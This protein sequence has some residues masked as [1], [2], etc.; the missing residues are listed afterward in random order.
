MWKEAAGC[1]LGVVFGKDPK[2]YAGSWLG[3]CDC[4]IFVGVDAFAYSNMGRKC[5]KK[6]RGCVGDALCHFVSEGIEEGMRWCACA[7]MEAGYRSLLD[8]GVCSVRRILPRR[9]CGLMRNKA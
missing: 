8:A 2:Q 6:V 7:L 3:V 4:G 5:W 9:G 1:R